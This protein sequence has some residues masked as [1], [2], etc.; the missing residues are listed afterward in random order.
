MAAGVY[1]VLSIA[2]YLALLTFSTGVLIYA[3]PL[4]WRSV[5]SWAPRLIGDSIYAVALIS[6]YLVI[7]K[8]TDYLLGLLGGSWDT[9]WSWVSSAVGFITALKTLVVTI[10]AA[11]RALQA[12]WVVSS[13]T[14]PIDRV[15]NLVLVTAA[16]LS[17]LGWLVSNYRD[18]LIALGI[19]LLSLP[20]RIGRWA[21]AW[22][23]AFAIVFYIG[24]P[25]LPAFSAW[26]AQPPSEGARFNFTVASV[27]LL[28]TTGGRVDSGVLRLSLTPGGDPIGVYPVED[29]IVDGKLG[30]GRVSLPSNTP[31]Y[32]SLELD[33][34]LLPLAP[35]P[36]T[37]E[38][39]G[40]L[41]P[42]PTLNLTAVNLAYSDGLLAV[43]TSSSMVSVA[44][45]V[46]GGNVTIYTWAPQEYY[47][48]VRYP[49]GCVVNVSHTA[50][51]VEEGSWE[52]RGVKGKTLR[53]HS[54]GAMALT[55]SY[56]GSC[57]PDFKKPEARDYLLDVWGITSLINS[58][59]IASIILY[60]ITLPIMYNLTLASLAYGL[61]RVLGGRE[62][63]MPK[64]I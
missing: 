40:I 33:G 62:R 32:A 35:Y 36:F 61:A 26:L 7:L 58:E 4:P 47:V 20:L 34:L 42:G 64:F 57:S 44:L 27:N 28:D 1:D 10:L 12:S 41:A 6:T 55:L 14:W 46:E 13:I 43:V 45:E 19:V 60:Y 48:D 22:L 30:P 9:F 29:G 49:E 51:A 25:L 52:W 11:A 54:D 15:A 3:L 59:T 39:S 37:V 16:T 56:S 38:E 63:F 31:I 23:I 17:G 2:Y 5:K 50:V 24:L 21:G 18:I 8:F 53:L